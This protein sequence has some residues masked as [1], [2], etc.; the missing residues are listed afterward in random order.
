MPL[1][2]IKNNRILSLF[3]LLHFNS[4]MG[5]LLIRPQILYSGLGQLLLE[6]GDS[7][8]FFNGFFFLLWENIHD[9]ICHWGH[10]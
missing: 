2:Q 5:S 6:G 7:C 1:S 4:K 10:F 3:I 9:K 8:F